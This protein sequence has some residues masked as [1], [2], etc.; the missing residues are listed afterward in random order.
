MD[1]VFTLKEFAGEYEGEGIRDPIEED[2][3]D[4]RDSA[5]EIQRTLQ[6]IVEENFSE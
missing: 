6:K 2:I 5:L 1:K 4:Y 3:H